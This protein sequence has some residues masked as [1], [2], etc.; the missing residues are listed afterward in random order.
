MAEPLVIQFAADTSRAT[1]AMSSLAASI[2]GNMASAG[3]ALSGMAAN[4][5]NAGSALGA[6]QQNVQRAAGAIGSDV[7]NIATATANAA[8][9][10]KATLEGVVRSFTAAAA[11]SQ[12]AQAGVKAGL[13]GTTTAVT[14]L[15][16][17]IPTLG[18]LLTAFIAFEAAKL[19]FHAVSASIDEARE[20]VEAFTQIAR[21]ADKVGLGTNI[22][23]RLTLD[24]KA[25]GLETRQVV[26]ALE[27]AKEAS[28]LRIGEGEHGRTTSTIADRVE[29]NVRAG[30]L[31]GGDRTALA[32][33]TTQE[34]RIRVVLDLI[35]KLRDAGR[36]V[37]A[38]DLAGKFFGADFEAKMRQG[39]ELTRR[40]RDQMDS[41]ALTAG[42][43][44]I[45]GQEEIDR[46]G[47]LEAKLRDIT[48]IFAT[49]LA[50]IQ[51]EFSDSALD[52]YTRFVDFEL[53]LARA[54][55]TASNLYVEISRIADKIA[56]M[57]PSAG[58]LATNLG[59]VALGEQTGLN[60]VGPAV[61]GALS[62]GANALGLT[63][64]FGLPRTGETQAQAD[65]R[66]ALTAA[67][68]VLANRMKQPGAVAQAIEDSN[69][70]DFRAPPKGADKSVTLPSL[71][72]KAPKG[73]TG[74]SEGL[75]AVETLIG[76]I[77]KARDTARA[78]LENVAKTNVERER[79]VAL[80][81]A[82]AVAREEVKKGNRESADLTEDE[83]KRVLAGAEAWQTY[84]D[85]TMDA[86]Q[87]IRQAADAARY[88]GD[89]AS[90]A[91][92]DAILEGRSFSDI[93]NSLVKQFARSAL[94]GVFTG[95]G[96]LSGLL[97]TAPKASSGDSVGGIAGLFQSFFRAN[98]GPVE[99]GQA[100]TVGERGRELFIP[101]ASGQIVPI[102]SQGN[103]GGG[104]TALNFIDQRPAGSP[105][106][107]PTTRRNAS[108]GTDIF[109]REAESSLFGRGRRGQGA[110]GPVLN[111][112]ATRTG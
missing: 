48:N 16:A 76:Q 105:D 90:T 70:L 44:R 22:Y 107:A 55:L 61:R 58:Q 1:S 3:V 37:A 21:D 45:V 4:S 68:Q 63:D 40:L 67:R 12:T 41:T 31:S 75:D 85:R 51:K 73:S 95:Q 5:N 26:A 30:N 111:T 91:F 83:R 52:I 13:T 54:V 100:Y 103:G 34:A 84:K 23:Q 93:L 112:A 110:L 92:A 56:N 96:P 29:Q 43:Q 47:Q 81:K 82:E 53:V 24:A 18:T 108:G 38:F 88:F 101:N 80:A 87:A 77:E 9:A 99:A 106:L 20:H 14:T 33:A 36:D 78:E 79:A 39:V 86:Q 42:G 57:I 2:A 49:A 59:A 10:E 97:G 50:P 19:V 17:Q 6:L 35:D 72:A 66:N 11:G 27:R 74:S 64:T 32:G 28:A 98:G 62:A 69:K 65:D 46:A 109:L 102:A 60:R 7:K 25:L 8:T 71:S 89:A 94:Q 104:V 15:A